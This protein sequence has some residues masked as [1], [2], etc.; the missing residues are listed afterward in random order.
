[1][2]PRAVGSVLGVSVPQQARAARNRS[3]QRQATNLNP[4][5]EVPVR[6]RVQRRG[7][8][9]RINRPD[10]AYALCYNGRN[11]RTTLNQLRTVLT[12]HAV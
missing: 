6:K 7:A 3:A 5:A 8:R 9:A 12:N 1:M 11:K 2:P 10:G 4:A